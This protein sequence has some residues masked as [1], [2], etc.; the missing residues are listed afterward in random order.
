MTT[1][2]ADDGRKAVELVDRHFEQEGDAR[3]RDRP[4]TTSN[5]PQLQPSGS[6]RRHRL[7]EPSILL[8]FTAVQLT[9][10]GALGYGLL[11]LLT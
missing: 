5:Q 11:R 7:H 4:E 8:I 6:M 9:W 2:A 10:L 3:P 1:I